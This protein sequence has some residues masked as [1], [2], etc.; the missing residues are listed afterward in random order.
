MRAG[1]KAIQCV[2]PD[3]VLD[4][5]RLSSE[6]GDWSAEKIEAKTGIRERHIAAEGEC[7]S[8]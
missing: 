5:V 8:D 2:L 7:A 1:I 6:L 3:C 4:N